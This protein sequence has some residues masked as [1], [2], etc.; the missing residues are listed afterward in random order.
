MPGSSLANDGKADEV[1]PHASS[2]STSIILA[3]V[4][5][6]LY[7]GY[8]FPVAFLDG[9][10]RF[11]RTPPIEDI[12]TELAG[13]TY[14]VSDEWRFPIFRTVPISPPN[15]V[16]IVYTDSLPLLAL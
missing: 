2:L 11:W 1:T 10:S 5:G 16:S 8:L 14:Y 9:S 7:A 15:G 6:F 4:I 3:A 12:A 13:L